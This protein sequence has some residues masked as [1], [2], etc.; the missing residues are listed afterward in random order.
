MEDKVL[1][2]LEY[3]TRREVGRCERESVIGRWWM[4]ERAGVVGIHRSL[5][6]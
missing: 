6:G 4:H 1:M 5:G 2:M 3:P